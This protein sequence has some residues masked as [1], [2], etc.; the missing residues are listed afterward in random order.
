M[1]A[2]ALMSNNL[3]LARRLTQTTMNEF[4]LHRSVT[5]FERVIKTSEKLAER[6]A[7]SGAMLPMLFSM[8]CAFKI[9]RHFEDSNS[10]ETEETS[11]DAAVDIQPI[12]CAILPTFDAVRRGSQEL[13]I[14][15]LADRSKIH[16]VLERMGI[17]TLCPVSS[18]QFA[19]MERLARSVM[20]RAQVIPLLD[21]ALFAIEIGDYPRASEHAA[22][23]RRLSPSGYE[24]YTLSIVEG[25]IAVQAGSLREATQFLSN[26]VSAC[27]HNEYSSLSCGVRGLNLALA[28]KLLIN[29]H[30]VE[31]LMHLARCRNVWESLGGQ[32][33]EWISQIERGQKPQFQESAR[34]RALNEP[35]YQL[36][37]QSSRLHSLEDETTFSDSTSDNRGTRYLF[38]R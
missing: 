30:K 1:R 6:N 29:G 26:S 17:S 21:I 9:R 11:Q 38:P 13:L 35:A 5:E 7:S 23:A 8:W 34:L 12:D 25:L 24:L 19:R 14:M 4:D 28:E 16:D 36:L 3:F 33:D 10:I 32:I 22:E 15:A 37:M 2:F 27:Q 20:G 18:H 31:V